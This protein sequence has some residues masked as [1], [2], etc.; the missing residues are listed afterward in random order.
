[1]NVICS[2]VS[3]LPCEQE[4]IAVYSNST[5]VAIQLSN[6]SILEYSAGLLLWQ[7]GV[8]ERITSFLC[9]V[10]EGLMPWML[11]DGSSLQLKEPCP[12]MQ[13][14]TFNGKVISV[15]EMIKTVRHSL[16]HYRMK[17]LD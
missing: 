11:K 5:K 16:L 4:V 14:A 2:K 9:C 3:A 12:H 7:W 8:V 6:G 13:L 15:S 10:E 17:W 1:M